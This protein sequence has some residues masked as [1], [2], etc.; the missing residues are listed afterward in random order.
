M[1]L[2]QTKIYRFGSYL[3]SPIFNFLSEIGEKTKN[4]RLAVMWVIVLFFAVIVFSKYYFVAFS[5]KYSLGVDISN[6]SS[7]DHI[8]FSVHKKS[9]SYNDAK[10][11]QYIMFNTDKMEPIIPKETSIIKKIVAKSGDHVQVVGL[12]MFINGQMVAKL[13]PQALE[14]LHKT[15]ADFQRD[16]IVSPNSVIIL[17]SYER[18]FDSRYWGELQFRPNEKLNLATPMLF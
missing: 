4:K 14:R 11:G 9:L 18:S 10:V 17:G 16:F 15:E 1:Q 2:K 7:N 5:S 8:L 6:I 12:Q 3:L 13:R